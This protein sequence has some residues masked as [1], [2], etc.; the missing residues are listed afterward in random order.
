[1]RIG[2]LKSLIGALGV[3]LIIIVLPS[4]AQ[5]QTFKNCRELNKKYQDGIAINFGVVGTSRAR[6]DRSLFIRNQRLDRD[7]DGLVCENEYLQG[8]AT[9]TTTSTVPPKTRT[10][11]VADLPAFVNSYGGS[12]VTIE[13]DGG[14][15]SGVSVPFGGSTWMNELGGKSLIVTNM[16]VVIDC[17]YSGTNWRLNQVLI[18]HKGVEYVGYVSGWPSAA[19]YLSG[20]KADLAAVMTT[21]TVPQTSYRDVRRPKLGDAVV[22]IGSAGGIPNVTTRGDIAAVTEKDIV[23]TSPAGHGSSG[24]ALFN[25]DGQLLGFIYSA[26][27]SLIQ[28]VP[29]PRLC[30][31]VFGCSTPITYL[32]S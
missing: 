4:V 7:R 6:I 13:C 21:G 25:N 10:T 8:L 17:I 26:N 11:P 5:A 15:G 22:A 18:R 9:T 23:T 24:G 12:V 16:H 32:D 28:V 14:Q 19:D 2:A 27:A 29:I 3:L 31:A 20:A 30:E 1:V